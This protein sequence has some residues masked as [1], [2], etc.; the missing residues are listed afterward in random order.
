M[1]NPIGIEVRVSFTV[2]A[3]VL[4]ILA[5]IPYVRGVSAGKVQPH[6]FSWIIWGITTCIVFFAQLVSHGG[7]GT[8]PIA[9][10]GVTTFLVA[11]FAYQRR[12][13]INIT[14]M[15]WFFFLLALSSLPFWFYF[16]SPLAAVIV[17]SLA[18]TLGF[19]P[20]IRKGYGLPHSEPLGF[21]LAF[22]FR[23]TLAMLALAEWN[24]TNLLFPGSVGLTCLVFVLLVKFRQQQSLKSGSL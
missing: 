19:I 14:K 22:L 5:Y 17:L 23:N 12:G 13:K 4:T 8:L 15:D 24:F 21:Y 10:S 6:V 9:F 1:T 2:I 7:I 16:S 11:I 18:D 20:T 3:V